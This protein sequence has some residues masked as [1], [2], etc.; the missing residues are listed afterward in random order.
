MVNTQYNM[1][2]MYY[3]L[4]PLKPVY[5]V[6]NHCHPDTVNYKSKNL[7]HSLHVFLSYLLRFIKKLSMKNKKLLVFNN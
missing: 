6:I 1:Q 2:M 4:V 3:I 7:T 5:V